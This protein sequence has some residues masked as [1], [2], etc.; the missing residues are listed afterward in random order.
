M[1]FGPPMD[2][3]KKGIGYLKQRGVDVEAQ[4][5]LLNGHTYDDLKK[6]W[7]TMKTDAKL[8]KGGKARLV[9][10]ILVHTH[11]RS[12]TAKQKKRLGAAITR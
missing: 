11:R 3:V 7:R 9:D 1:N 6:A 4:R 2:P 12:F 10:A 5:T 8:P